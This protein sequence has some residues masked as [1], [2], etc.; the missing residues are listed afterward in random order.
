MLMEILYTPPCTICAE[1]DTQPPQFNIFWSSCFYLDS[2]QEVEILM[3]HGQC[4][5]HKPCL[6][7]QMTTHLAINQVAQ[8]TNHV[9][10]LV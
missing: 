4:T 2:M 6:Q 9:M 8:R 7:T 3:T 10:L 5:V 1:T